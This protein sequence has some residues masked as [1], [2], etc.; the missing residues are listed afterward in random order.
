MNFSVEQ[1]YDGDALHFRSYLDKYLQ[2][3]EK[4]SGYDIY[5]DGLKIYVALDSRMQKYAE[6]A[7]NK[8]MRTL[9]R[10]FFDH[11]RGQNPWQDENRKEIPNFIEDKA[12]KTKYY[13][14]LKKR[15]ENNNDSI[16]KYLNLPRRTKVFDYD[17]VEKDTTMSV[18]DSIR[19]MN[20]FLHG[21]FVAMEPKTGN[22][23]AWV[24]D[25]DFNSGNTIKLHNPNG[26]PGLHLNF[27]CTRQP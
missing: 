15:F 10:R 2:D 16:E 3:W 12:K 26:N 7:V 22:V 25:I 18:M 11:W 6:E 1:S 13:A 20:H 4:E 24:G 21:S 5:S 23:R 8:Q 27:L 17:L 9:Q 19:Y 14:S